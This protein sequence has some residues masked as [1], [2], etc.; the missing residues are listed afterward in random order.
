MASWSSRRSR[1]EL[2]RLAGL[3]WLTCAISCADAEEAR[4][5][6][7]PVVVDGS[8]MEPVATNLG[9][10]VQVQ[11]AQ[12]A[13]SDLQFSIAGEVHT[14]S[15]APL[16]ALFLSTARAHPGHYTGGEVTGELL[17]R[18]V[19]DWTFGHG[20]ELGRATLLEGRY[21]SANM[22]LERAQAS[23]LAADSPLLGHSAWI[24]GTAARDGAQIPFVALLDAPRGRQIVGFPFDLQ[25]SADTDVRLGLKL[26]TV[27]PLEQDTL[28][29]DIDFATLTLESSGSFVGQVV[30]EEASTAP[31]LSAYQRL[32]RTLQSHDHFVVH[33][34]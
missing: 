25:V 13:V 21:D 14:S 23:D 27:D 1:R 22:T 5:V 24:R 17:G 31:N 26:C 30:L 10:T 34:L 7:L 9:Y 18:F 12:L 28:F 29:D 8:C 11:E 19:L 3:A 4:R 33:P 20:I 6:E 2:E 32:K 16:R 15:R